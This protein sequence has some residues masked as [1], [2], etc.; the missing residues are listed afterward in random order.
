MSS[1]LFEEAESAVKDDA[2]TLEEAESAVKD[3]AFTLALD[4][5]KAVETSEEDATFTLSTCDCLLGVHFAALLADLRRAIGENASAEDASKISARRAALLRMDLMVAF[6]NVP[7]DVL[8]SCLTGGGAP[9]RLAPSGL[10]LAIHRHVVGI[11][12]E[13]DL[14]AL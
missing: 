13:D 12:E 5:A 1:S 4:E 10:F 11:L 7:T 3:D 2:F 8:L 14:P 6:T 9:H